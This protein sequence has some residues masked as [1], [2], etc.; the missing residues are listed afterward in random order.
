M[1]RALDHLRGLLLLTA[2]CLA[3]EEQAAIIGPDGTCRNGER[4]CR[5]SRVTSLAFLRALIATVMDG[6]HQRDI[7][8][9]LSG[10]LR[11]FSYLYFLE[12]L[13]APVRRVGNN[14]IAPGPVTTTG[15]T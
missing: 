13:I 6:N 8:S 5:E 11:I 15:S 10:E 12:V 4:S 7:E 1:T 9:G 2:W 14:R 3:A